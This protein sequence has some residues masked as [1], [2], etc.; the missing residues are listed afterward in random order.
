MFICFI[1]V[2]DAVINPFGVGVITNVLHAM[3]CIGI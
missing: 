2:F 3:E 1:Y